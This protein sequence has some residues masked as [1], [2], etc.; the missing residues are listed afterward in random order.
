M[1]KTQMNESTGW[2]RR[3]ITMPSSK[4]LKVPKGRFRM[5][6][7]LQPSK[8]IHKKA[9]LKKPISPHGLRHTC[10]THLLKG[11]ADIRQIQELLGHESIATTQRYTRV[12]I[13][14]L[15]RV[16]KRHHP[17]ERGEIETNER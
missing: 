7:L 12:E 13:A 1:L 17:R 3:R 2:H 6:L 5:L 16:L 4:N 10:A 9:G 8:H 15:K 14:D 11:K